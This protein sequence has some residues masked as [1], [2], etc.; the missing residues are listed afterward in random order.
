MTT[1]KNVPVRLDPDVWLAFKIACTKRRQSMQE[2][3]EQ[4]VRVYV[5][6]D[7]GGEPRVLGQS[8]EDMASRE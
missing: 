1:P 7:E 3:L 4:F 8:L 5:E 6:M 2:V